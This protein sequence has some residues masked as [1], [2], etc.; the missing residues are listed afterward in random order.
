MR[1][2]IR[3][4]NVDCIEKNVI[5]REHIE[6]IMILVPDAQFEGTS[7]LGKGVEREYCEKLECPICHSQIFVYVGKEKGDYP[8]RSGKSVEFSK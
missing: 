6:P 3:C 2:E 1:F 4:A 5:N 7:M 8:I